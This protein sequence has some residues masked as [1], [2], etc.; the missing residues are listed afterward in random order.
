MNARLQALRRRW[1]ALAKREKTMVVAAATVVGVALLWMLA[2]GPALSTLRTADAQRRTLDAQLQR[3]IALQAQAQSLQAQPKQNHDEAVRQL[4]AA[5]RQG[6]GASGRMA[7][8]GERATITLT[9]AAP[10][11]LAQWL[12]QARLNARAIPAEAHLVRNA[13]GAWD[14]SLVL[15]LPSK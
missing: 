4:E 2:V 1:A 10:D 12:A 9:G 5:V 3:M 6:L 14:G 8:Q 15:T 11:A 7:I 13:G